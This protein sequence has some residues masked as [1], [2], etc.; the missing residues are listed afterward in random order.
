MRWVIWCILSM[1]KQIPWYLG[2]YPRVNRCW[3]SHQW[4]LFA[5]WIL[6]PDTYLLDDFHTRIFTHSF[7]FTLWYL[8]VRSFLHLDI[9]PLVNI[10][11]G[12]YIRLCHSHLNIYQLVV[13]TMR[14]YTHSLILTPCHLPTLWF[15]ARK[16]TRLLIFKT[17]RIRA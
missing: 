10:Y 11:P 16:F 6:H 1:K 15:L 8:P 7:I 17:S 4:Q 13:S 3:F 2:I 9:Y 5:R 12:A 14:T